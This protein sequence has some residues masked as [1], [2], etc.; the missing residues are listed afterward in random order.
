MKKLLLTLSAAW[1]LAGCQSEPEPYQDFTEDYHA[2]YQQITDILV[3]DIFSP[4]VAA[5]IYAYTGA[6]GYEVMAQQ[7]SGYALLHGQVHEFPALPAVPESD[8]VAEIAALRAASQ[9]GKALVFSEDRMEAFQAEL[10]DKIGHS[11]SPKELETSLAYGDQVATVVLDWASKDRYNETR[12]FT[13]YEINDDPLRWKP[14]PPDYMDGIEPHWKNIRTLI[15]DSASMFKPVPP[16]TP[17]LDTSSEFWQD[18]L[19]VYHAVNALKEG[20]QDIAQF[21]DCNPYVSV[22]KGHVMLATKKITPGGHWVGI[23]AI[24]CRKAEADFG[25]TI[26]AYLRTSLGL[27]DAFI[28]CWDEKY[29]SSLVRPE[30]IIN[31]YIDEDWT[32]LL[33]TP[34]FPEYTSGHSVISACA[35]DM[36]TGIFGDNFAF[37]DSTERPYGLEDRY[38]DSFYHASSEAGIS[39]LYGGIHYMPAIEEG[40]TQG[41]N[42]GAYINEKLVTKLP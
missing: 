18:V 31:A 10:F 25:T 37:Q 5:R 33:Q 30:T 34:P 40:L 4:P 29:R 14:T 17:S 16:P 41:H 1:L 32:P 39:R 38:F 23:T 28:S 35:S 6:A 12:T 19:E 26:N 13:K 27:H 8:Y 24:A 21:W 9:V 3:H 7:D 20:E 11:F 22:H 15:L 42:V 36:L 2:M